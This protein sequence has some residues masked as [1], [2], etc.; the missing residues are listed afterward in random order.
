MM[1]GLAESALAV[2]VSVASDLVAAAAAPAAAAAGNA[3]VARMAVVAPAAVVEP[4]AAGTAADLDC[5]WSLDSLFFSG[6][7]AGH[8]IVPP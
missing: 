1:A 3:A 6:D 5:C 7:H 2:A 4:V 8:S